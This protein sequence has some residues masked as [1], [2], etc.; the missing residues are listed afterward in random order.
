MQDDFINPPVNKMICKI[1]LRQISKAQ[2]L[3]GGRIKGESFPGHSISMKSYKIHKIR[4]VVAVLLAAVFCSGCPALHEIAEDALDFGYRKNLEETKAEM[5]EGHTVELQIDRKISEAVEQM[6]ST[7]KPR[8]KW[9]IVRKYRLGFLEVFDVDRVEVTRLHNYITE[10][11]LTFS[12]LHPDIAENFHI[13]ERFL[14]KDIIRELDIES[15][16]PSFPNIF[17]ENRSI[18]DQ[19]LA[20]KLGKVYSV[21]LIETGVVTESSDFL[22]INLRMIETERGRIVAVGSVKIEKTEPVRKW[23][24]ETVGSN[25]VWPG[26]FR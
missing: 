16:N 24:Y 26:S 18:V 5:L 12:F 9:H 7:L 13:V 19:T 20:K 14:L 17:G 10:K 2:I 4:I 21:D 6:V 8:Y 11:S 22:D 25:I 15:P 3:P 23:L 1:V